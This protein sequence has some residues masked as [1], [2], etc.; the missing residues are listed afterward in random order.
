MHNAMTRSGLE[1]NSSGDIS[2]G[3]EKAPL[4]PNL[5]AQKIPSNDFFYICYHAG[6]STEHLPRP[7]V[8]RR[9]KE[10]SLGDALTPKKRKTGFAGKM[11]T[12]L[13]ACPLTPTPQPH[14]PSP[15]L[16]KI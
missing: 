14:L 2:V 7:K 11:R 9:A 5:E 12:C 4:L 1:A 6:G 15:C 8:K 13:W 16:C 10:S 3:K